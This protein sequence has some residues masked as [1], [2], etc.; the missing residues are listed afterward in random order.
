MTKSGFF[1]TL[2]T[3]PEDIKIYKVMLRKK[4]WLGRCKYYAPY[5]GT[6][7]KLNREHEVKLDIPVLKWEDSLSRVYTVDKGLYSYKAD[8]VKLEY[9][10][11]LYD[12]VMNVGYRV[13]SKQ[14]DYYDIEPVPEWIDPFYNADYVLMEGYI[15]KGGKY[16]INS[17]GEI[18]SN[19]LVITGV[20]KE[21]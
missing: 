8:I 17:E 14:G 3:A 18:V 4:F 15:P 13:T 6:R 20:A 11:Q 21:D 2:L 10:H 12:A 9:C 7:Y 5:R 16:Y 1:T 19:R